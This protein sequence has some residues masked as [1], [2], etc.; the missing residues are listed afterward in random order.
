MDGLFVDSPFG[1]AREVFGFCIHHQYPLC[2]KHTSQ[3]YL[4]F[5]V[6]FQRSLE[7]SRL[8]VLIRNEKAAQ[9]VSLGDGYPAAVHADIPADVRGQKLRQAHDPKARTSM[10]PGVFQKLRSEKLRAEFSF[11]ILLHNELVL[12]KAQ[13]GEPFL[14]ILIISFHFSVFVHFSFW[15]KAGT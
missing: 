10:T 4:F 14:G 11:P 12:F 7:H 13:L 6:L 8:G 5:P 3:A 1:P 15:G 2:V 9:R